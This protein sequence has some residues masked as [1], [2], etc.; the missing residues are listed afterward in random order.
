MGLELKNK[1][2]FIEEYKQLCQKYNL[3]F[4]VNCHSVVLA[5]RK[6]EKESFRKKVKEITTMYSDEPI[7]N[8]YFFTDDN[9]KIYKMGKVKVQPYWLYKLKRF[10]RLAS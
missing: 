6:Y 9:V 10:F 4:D 1:N 8:G 5:L 2:E 7:F 3:Q